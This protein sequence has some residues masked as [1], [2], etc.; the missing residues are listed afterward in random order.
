[1]RRH[2]SDEA[3]FSDPHAVICIGNVDAANSGRELFI[4]LTTVWNI[5]N[6]GRGLASG[7]PNTLCGDGTGKFSKKQATMISLGIISIPAKYN[8]LNFA[9]GPVENEDIF[10]QSWKGVEATWYALMD[11][12][13]WKICPM[14]SQH[15]ALC[16]INGMG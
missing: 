13:R 14:S 5:L 1:M 15:C 9:V 2:N 6:L 11:N 8:A 10:Y 7:W 3:H 16:P 4:N 12:K